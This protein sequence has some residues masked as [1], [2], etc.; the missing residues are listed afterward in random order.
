MW[1]GLAIGTGIEVKRL[2]ALSLALKE[3]SCRGLIL[4]SVP[5]SSWSLNLAGHRFDQ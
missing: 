5:E 1:L 4:F 3:I 2:T